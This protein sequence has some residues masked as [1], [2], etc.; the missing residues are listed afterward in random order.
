MEIKKHHTTTTTATTEEVVEDL[1]QAARFG[2]PVDG[3]L[4]RHGDIDARAGVDGWTALHW[5]TRWSN[6]STIVQLLAAGAS[7]NIPDNK[8]QTT[9]HIAATYCQRGI[10]AL[11]MRAGGDDN[12]RDNQGK[13]PNHLLSHKVAT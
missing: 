13:T 10:W 7:P 6:K 1:V 11:L 2:L 4:Q 3:L 12:I 8:G 9:L 5:A